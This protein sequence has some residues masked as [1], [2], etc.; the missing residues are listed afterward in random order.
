MPTV[1]D[2]PPKAGSPQAGSPKEG[3]AADETI[4][5]PLVADKY[6]AAAAAC[7][8]ALQKV[9]AAA[10]P[11]AAV[12]ALA[13]LGDAEVAEQLK[14]VYAAKKPAVPKG[15]SFPCCVCVNRCVGH[16]SPPEDDASP[17]LAVGD[18]VKLEIGAHVDGYCAVAAHTLVVLD[19]AAGEVPGGLIADAIACAAATAQV[20]PRMLRAGTKNEEIM[21]ATAQVATDFG[22]T[23][24]QGTASTELGRYCY[25]GPEGAVHYDKVGMSKPTKREGTVDEFSVWSLEMCVAAGGQ[26]TLSPE[27]GQLQARKPT[28][29]KR[30]QDAVPHGGIRLA[31]AREVLKDSQ[32]RFGDLPFSLRN[33]EPKVGA[34][35]RELFNHGAMLPFPVL[36]TVQPNEVVARFKITAMVTPTAVTLLT[37]LP[38]QRCVTEGKV[39]DPKMKE[40]AAR[41]LPAPKKRQRKKKGGA[42]H[43]DAAA[44]ADAAEADGPRGA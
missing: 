24:V 19:D 41:A 18:S 30:R 31:A 20:L 27:L 36:E 23:V 13:K 5:N 35:V 28:I 4:R 7:N 21:E 12:L 37:G 39:T 38:A 43:V 10:R 15:L 2:S 22:L 16:Y 29:G 42:A 34:C 6:R 44:G 11:G 25:D 8:A 17:P 3:P 9:V 1:R 32:E 33:L 26:K 40:I 14:D